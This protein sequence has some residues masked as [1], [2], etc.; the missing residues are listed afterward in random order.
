MEG[1]GNSAVSLSQNAPSCLRSSH[2]VA[3]P[4]LVYTKCLGALSKPVLAIACALCKPWLV[5]YQGFAG[6]R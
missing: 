1:T 6:Q 5:L 3:T 4:D 2:G